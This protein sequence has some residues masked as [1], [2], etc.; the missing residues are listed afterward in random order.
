MINSDV[1]M[2]RQRRL[3]DFR[4]ERLIGNSQT[5]SKIKEVSPGSITVKIKI[6]IEDVWVKKEDVFR[7][8]F[9]NLLL[10][11]FDV[12]LSEEPDVLFY[13]VFGDDHKKTKY[14]NCL[15]VFYTGENVKPDYSV[16]DYAFTF[17]PTDNRNFQLPNFSRFKSFQFLRQNRYPE[18]L[19]HLREKP[20]IKFCNFIYSNS[21]A[22]ERKQ[23]FE[24]LSTYKHV[25]APGEVMNNMVKLGH[26][27][28]PKV[29]FMSDYKFTIA[30]E[31][32]SALHYTTEK[33]FHAFLVKSIPIYW[34]NEAVAT[35]FNPEAFINVHDFDSFESAME[36]VKNV[37]QHEGLYNRYLRSSPI[38]KSSYLSGLSEKRILDRIRLILETHAGSKCRKIL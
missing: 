2:E 20:K 26:G 18:A 21:R 15:K 31:N 24:L 5:P 37:D 19:R 11:H 9:F 17:E 29:E 8:D 33:I 23:F 1:R 38:P 28:E 4:H 12:E 22:D 36:Y 7:D 25:D 35:L 6:A 30:F 3:K 10:T 34:G 14:K 32:E 16:C 13:S 27:Y